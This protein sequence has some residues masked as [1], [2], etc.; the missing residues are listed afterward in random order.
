MLISV[1]EATQRIQSAIAPGPTE[2]VALGVAGG[3]ILRAPVTASRPI[4]PFDRVMM[5]GVAVARARVLA[6]VR[7][8][9]VA[10]L[11]HAGEPAAELSDPDSCRR[12]MTGA[13]CPPGADLVVPREV[14]RYEDDWAEIEAGFS[15]P[16]DGFIHPAGSDAPAGAVLLEAGCRLGAAE[17]GLAANGAASTVEVARRP[18]IAIVSTG[19]ELVEPGAAFAPHQVPRSN[20]YA[21]AA[22]LPA[23]AAVELELV[24]CADDR[25]ELRQRLGE[26]LGRVD[27]VVTSGGVSQGDRDFLPGIWRELGLTELFH[28][29]AQRPGKPLWAGHSATGVLVFGLPGNPVSTVVCGRRYVVPAIDRWLGRT[30]APVP[31]LQVRAL[32]PRARPLT[33][34]VVVRRE[35]DEAIPLAV[36]N[37]GDFVHLRGS[38]GFVELPPAPEGDTPGRV[39]S[40][41]PW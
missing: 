38:D 37:S 16:E 14:V 30:T 21:L 26:L 8:F 12:V 7:R 5:D 36:R 39:A 25:A 10:G 31:L 35:G 4:P 2:S 17:M 28:G 24:H 19:D 13:V 22:L 27:F 32:P 1:N 18:R 23:H 34:F 9:R 6:G 33:A 11:T 41:F 29:V 20:V 3:R 15:P 40:F